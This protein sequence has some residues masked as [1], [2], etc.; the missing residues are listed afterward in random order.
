MFVFEDER[1]DGGW[2]SIADEPCAHLELASTRFVSWKQNVCACRSGL[3]RG[4]A[5]TY[6]EWT[7]RDPAGWPERLLRKLGQIFLSQITSR[8]ALS[9]QL[10]LFDGRPS[11]RGK[12]FRECRDEAEK[13]Y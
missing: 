6:I 4:V 5:G 2:R 11:R 10:V 12:T 8:D 9:R 3:T 7:E 13:R 1:L